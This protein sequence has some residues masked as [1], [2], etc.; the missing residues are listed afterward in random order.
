MGQSPINHFIPPEV[1]ALAMRLIVRNPFFTGKPVDVGHR[2]AQQLGTFVNRN[3]GFTVAS[4]IGD[5]AFNVL[6]L[7]KNFSVRWHWFGS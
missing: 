3:Y 1:D 4:L 2:N 7:P 6:Q 5:Q